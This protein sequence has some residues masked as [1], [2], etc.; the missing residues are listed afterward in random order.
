MT[1]PAWHRGSVL[2]VCQPDLFVTC[3]WPECDHSAAYEVELAVDGQ[4]QAR[5]LCPAHYGELTEN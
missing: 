5:R 3:E 1:T 2:E 4:W